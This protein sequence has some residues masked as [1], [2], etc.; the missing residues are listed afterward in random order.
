MISMVLWLIKVGTVT[1]SENLPPSPFAVCFLELLTLYN[2]NSQQRQSHPPVDL[3]STVRYLKTAES[4]QMQVFEGKEPAI[5]P[6]LAQFVG[7]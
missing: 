1:G 4:E 2:I 5:F 7:T 6:P 3:S